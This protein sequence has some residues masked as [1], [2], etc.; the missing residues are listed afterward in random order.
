M[1]K[2]LF[3]NQIVTFFIKTDNFSRVSARVMENH[4]F[5]KSLCEHC[6]THIHHESLTIFISIYF[7]SLT[8]TTVDVKREKFVDH[9]SCTIGKRTGLRP[10]F[11]RLKKLGGEKAF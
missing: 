6:I 7:K 11:Q 5:F 4:E 10:T 2:G 1:G 9:S 8:E 3:G